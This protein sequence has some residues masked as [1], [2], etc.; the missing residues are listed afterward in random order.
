MSDLFKFMVDYIPPHM[1]NPEPLFKASEELLD[2]KVDSLYIRPDQLGGTIPPMFA[3]ELFSGM[4]DRTVEYRTDSPSLPNFRTD[5]FEAVLINLDS[6]VLEHPRVN[7]RCGVLS[8]DDMLRELRG[9]YY[10]NLTV[11]VALQPGLNSNSRAFLYDKFKVLG[12]DYIVDSHIWSEEDLADIVARS[13]EV[14]LPVIVKLV[15]PKSLRHL[16]LLGDLAGVQIAGDYLAMFDNVKTDGAFAATAMAATVRLLN[17]CEQTVA[18]AVVSA[19]ISQA[20]YLRNSLIGSIEGA[21]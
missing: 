20:G 1:P 2:A 11:G 14:S 17:L 13:M 10:E 15:V 6:I 19:D 8:S 5:M 21:S 7:S 16:K 18:G 12:V 9:P 3:A 4:F